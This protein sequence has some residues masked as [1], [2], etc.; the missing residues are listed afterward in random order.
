VKKAFL[1]AL[2][3]FLSI[4]SCKTT[5]TVKSTSPSPAPATAECNYTTQTQCD[6]YRACKWDTAVAACRPSNVSTACSDQRDANSCQ[7]ARCVWN[8]GFCGE[9]VISGSS[10]DCKSLLTEAKCR[11]ESSRCSWDSVRSE[12]I[13]PG[14]FVVDCNLYSSSKT[15][16][17]SYPNQCQWLT[18]TNPPKCA[19]LAAV[20][21]SQ[22]CTDTVNQ[23]KSTCDKLTTQCR[24]DTSTN[25]CVDL[26][27][28]QPNPPSGAGCAAM[29]QADCLK[30]TSGCAWDPNNNI[31]YT[32]YV[33]RCHLYPDS[34]NCGLNPNQCAWDG[35]KCS[36][37]EP[38]PCD[39]FR[40]I[41]DCRGFPSCAWDYFRFQCYRR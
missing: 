40:W 23:V 26:S 9:P 13:T 35:M 11:I 25:R 41:S 30:D 21:P 4:S 38:V 31:C 32:A 37:I 20:L 8:N 17:D 39:K 33:V 28:P 18:S 3:I 19:P 22:K 34:A 6:K 2:Y 12:C 29:P 36:N 24:W 14:S 7:L 1:F 15:N 10:F 16:C 27:T 5:E